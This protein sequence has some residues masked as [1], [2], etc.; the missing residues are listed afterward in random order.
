MIYYVIINKGTEVFCHLRGHE[1]EI[2]CMRSSKL[3]S[4][5]KD[6]RRWP[7]P[8]ITAVNGILLLLNNNDDDVVVGDVDISFKEKELETIKHYQY[9]SMQAPSSWVHSKAGLQ[10]RFWRQWY[11]YEGSF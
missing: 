4:R 8:N 10:G 6:N 2:V 1:Y 11:G 7:L 9:M 5:V 3:S